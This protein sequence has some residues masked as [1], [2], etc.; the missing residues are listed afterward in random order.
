MS[1]NSGEKASESRSSSHEG[2]G[3]RSEAH[4]NAGASG[5]SK[6]MKW[7]IAS[8][9]LAGTF[10]GGWLVGSPSGGSSEKS[11]ETQESAASEE[12]SAASSGSAYE[13]A[14]FI[15]TA[16]FPGMSGESVFPAGTGSGIYISST[17]L[18][19]D[20]STSIVY[21][22]GGKMYA[23]ITGFYADSEPPRVSSADP[24][25]TGKDGNSGSVMKSGSPSHE[26][27]VMFRNSG[28]C[29]D[30]GDST[31]ELT[32]ALKDGGALTCSVGGED[33]VMAFRDIRDSRNSRKAE[34]GAAAIL[35]KLEPGANG[36]EFCSSIEQVLNVSS[37]WFTRTFTREFA[38]LTK[39]LRSS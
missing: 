14:G 12:A 34:L 36:D 16:L 30:L 32:L 19:A 15:D 29:H 7:A 13:A 20:G 26:L 37:A 38:D 10:A 8:L 1:R 28:F 9:L 31:A 18:N 17:R 22:K 3:G 6:V 27:S 21:S 5:P 2:S 35:L 24:S 23:E 25:F 33:Y 11:H 4:P 39:A